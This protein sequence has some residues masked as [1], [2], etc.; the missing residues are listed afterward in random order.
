MWGRV[1]GFEGEGAEYGGSGSDLTVGVPIGEFRPY[2]FKTFTEWLETHALKY[3]VV[4]K[5]P[6]SLIV[7][8][9]PF[10]N[11]NQFYGDLYGHI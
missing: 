1:W 5:L 2:T 11:V 10:Q 4:S 7:F 6:V 9:W 8:K 3:L